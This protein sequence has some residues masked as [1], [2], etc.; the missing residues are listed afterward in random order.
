MGER[1]ATTTA[2]CSLAK[3]FRHGTLPVLVNL[4]EIMDR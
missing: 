3:P 4:T 2:Y 1:Q